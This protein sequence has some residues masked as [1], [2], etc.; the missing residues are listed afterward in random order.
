MEMNNETSCMSLITEVDNTTNSNEWMILGTPFFRTALVS[1]DYYNNTIAIK[2]KTTNSPIIAPTSDD[3]KTGLSEGAIWG[4][5]LG[6]IAFLLILILAITFACC[7]KKSKKELHY[8]EID[9][10]GTVQGGTTL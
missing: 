8:E 3:S 10:A 5:S 4:I 7:H 1:F 2:S 9:A 6:C